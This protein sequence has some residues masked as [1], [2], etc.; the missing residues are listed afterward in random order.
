MSEAALV[1]RILA[2]LRACG[3]KAIKIHGGVYMEAGT[4]DVIGA[5]MGRAFAIEVKLPGKKPEP[6]QHKRLAEWAA[7]GAIS[8]WATSVDEALA[9]V[10]LQRPG[11]GRPRPL[12]GSR[13]PVTG[14]GADSDSPRC[15]RSA[16]EASAR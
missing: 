9:L 12:P 2:A 5:H 8:G 1:T 4:P 16:R 6:I 7:A 13:Q 11:P 15:A 3:A 10:G 14:D